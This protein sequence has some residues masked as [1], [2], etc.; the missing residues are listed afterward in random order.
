MKEEGKICST[1]WKKVKIS[2]WVVREGFTKKVHIINKEW[3]ELWVSGERH[4]HQKEAQRV[5]NP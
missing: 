1:W 5:Q 3:K 4:N 2:V